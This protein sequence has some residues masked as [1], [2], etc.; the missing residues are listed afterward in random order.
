MMGV[1]CR[2]IFLLCLHDLTSVCLSAQSGLAL[3]SFSF[4]EELLTSVFLL[5]F[6]KESV[7]IAVSEDVSTKLLKEKGIF[8]FHRLSKLE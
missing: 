4:T 5:V 2:L 1:A 8:C 6:T 3:S 7:H